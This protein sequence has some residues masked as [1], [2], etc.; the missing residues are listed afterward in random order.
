MKP[1]ELEKTFI[2][3]VVDNELPEPDKE[4]FIE[5]GDIKNKDRLDGDDTRCKITIIDNDSP[6]IVGFKERDM[7][8]RP[9]D[10][11]LAVEIVR[12][13][14]CAGEATVEIEIIPAVDNSLGVPAV[15]GTDFRKLENPT[16]VF[17]AGMQS[18]T[19]RIDMPSSSLEPDGT[20]M[21]VEEDEEPEGAYFVVRIAKVHPE[22]VLLSRKRECLVEIRPG[23]E[24]SDDE[25]EKERRS[26]MKEFMVH[27]DPSWSQQFVIACMLG[28]AID[29]HG[30][31]D[32][33]ETGEAIFHWLAMPWKVFFAIVPPREKCGGWFAFVVALLQ[34]G[35]VTF[36]VGEVATVL[37]C[38]VGLETSVTA[39][40]L[41][42][43]GT[44][45]PDLFASASAAKNS[46]YADSAVG[47]VTGSNAVNVFLGMGLPWCI[48]SL[49]WHINKDG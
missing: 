10:Q 37:G 44:S 21:K 15:E 30:A 28:P 4:F 36:V 48:S 8:V 1:G 26:M 31:L 33:V 47:N 18:Q 49:Y 27:K 42:A 29:E 40:T 12:E 24:K 23:N 14:G 46:P 16:I 2:I 34:I 5:L 20:P 19:I 7:V 45:L 3:D 35:I 22:G 11:V 43:L 25:A 13:E 6:G 41:V 32:E 39:I 38:A 9:K 17:A